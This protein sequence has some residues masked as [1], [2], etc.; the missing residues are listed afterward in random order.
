MNNELLRVGGKL[1]LSFG[2]EEELREV[3]GGELQADFREVG[4]AI[5]PEVLGQIILEKVVLEGA[6]LFRAPIPET[7]AGFPIGD[8]A[9][10]NVNAVLVERATDCGVGDGVAEHAV[11]HVALKVREAGDFAI[12]GAFPGLRLGKNSQMRRRECS[13][14]SIRIELWRSA[15]RDLVH[16]GL[17]VHVE[18]I[19]G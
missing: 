17:G 19:C 18:W 11:D 6:I 2:L 3:R 14:L 15:E 1:V 7:A 10:G 8:I 13:L 12:A 4:S 16:L 5:L 9:F